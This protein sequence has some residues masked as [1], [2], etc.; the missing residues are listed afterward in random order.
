MRARPQAAARPNLLVSRRIRPGGSILLESIADRKLEALGLVSPLRHA[1]A[2]L[3]IE[4]HAEADPEEPQRPQPL[5]RHADRALQVVH[6]EAVVL[7]GDF[8][9]TEEPELAAALKHVADIKE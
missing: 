3:G 9:R 6:V 2:M 1:V 4:R 5:H 7:R 8:V